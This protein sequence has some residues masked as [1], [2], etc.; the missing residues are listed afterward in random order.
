MKY[1]DLKI[2]YED[3][4]LLAYNK[5]P[6][7]LVQRDK[8][9][10][11]SL[12]ELAK[13]YIKA[14]YQ[15]PGAVFL[16]VAH[17]IDRPVSG[18]V[19]LA[20]TSKALE[21]INEMFKLRAIKKTYWAIVKALPP[22]EEGT[23]VHWIVKDEK[24]NKSRASNKESKGAQLC[25]L[26]YKHI[27]SSS[28]Y[29]LLEIKPQTGRHHQIRCQLGKIGSSIKGDLKY[30]SARSNEDGSI[31]LHARRLEFVHPITKENVVI[32]ARPPADPLWDYFVGSQ[33]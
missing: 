28:T 9:E 11:E 2:L 24:K 8:N 17:R 21:R 1:Q 29:H 13:S 31:H 23:L 5:P 20:K 10:A 3:N 4:H 26:D 32:T 12:E 14:R 15:K 25:E 19:L 6:R 18:V 33:P 30:G 7:L 16:G 27:G 22:E